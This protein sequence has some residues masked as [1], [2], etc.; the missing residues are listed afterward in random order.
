[1]SIFSF[2]EYIE[3][4]PY[5]VL[6][7]RKMR[8]SAGIMFLTGLI[9]TINGFVLSRYAII[10]WIMG[11]FVFSFLVGLLI[12]PK[13]SPP[14]I[15]ASLF[16]W[17]QSKLPIGAVQ[18]KFAW[19]LG[20]ILSS[21]ILVLSIFLQKDPT[22]FEPTCMLCMICLLLLYLETAFGICVGCKL[23]QGAI[24]IKLLPKPKEKP[25]CMG[26]SCAVN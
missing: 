6:D 7:E 10:P 9:A 2:G 23:Y 20:L 8:A 13:F 17:K 5:K 12:N 22:Y 19:S 21:T 15:I 4:R 24:A 14:V 3:G 18:K 1:M 16:V 25:N 11:G 26:D